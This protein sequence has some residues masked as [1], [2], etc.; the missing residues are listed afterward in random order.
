MP[1]TTA[2]LPSTK[3][4]ALALLVSMMGKAMLRTSDIVALEH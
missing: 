2:Q 3:Q 4:L 1:D